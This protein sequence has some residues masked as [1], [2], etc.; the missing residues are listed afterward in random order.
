MIEGFLANR[1]STTELFGPM[2]I[3]IGGPGC[4]RRECGKCPSCPSDLD[5]YWPAEIKRIKQNCG[6][7]H[8]EQMFDGTRVLQETK[9]SCVYTLLRLHEWGKEP[10]INWGNDS[11]RDRNLEIGSKSVLW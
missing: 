8:D 1:F 4:G 5:F 11:S 7:K 9:N 2:R 3:E 6:H 10:N